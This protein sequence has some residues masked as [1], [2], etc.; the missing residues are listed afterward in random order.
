MSNNEKKNACDAPVIQK[1]LKKELII[2][3]LTETQTPIFKLMS[4]QYFK[5][6]QIDW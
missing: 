3:T 6:N 5:V 1:F 2:T 4:H